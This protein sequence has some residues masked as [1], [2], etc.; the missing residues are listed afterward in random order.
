MAIWIMMAMWIFM[1]VVM[2]K[3]GL[4]YQNI[5][6]TGH[7]LRL[8][9]EGVKSNRDALGECF[10]RHRNLSGLS[11]AISRGAQRWQFG[12]G[13]DTG[14]YF[15]LADAS[16][17]KR[18]EIHKFSGNVQ[19]LRDIAGD[20]FLQLLEDMSFADEVDLSLTW[21]EPWQNP[22]VAAGFYHARINL[23][24]F[25]YRAADAKVYLEVQ[26]EQKHV[27][28]QYL[29][30]KLNSHE[31]R[32]VTFKA[33]EVEAGQSYQ[34]R[35]WLMAK[36]D[37]YALNDR[38]TRTIQGGLWTGLLRCGW[39]MR[40]GPMLSPLLNTDSL[41]DLYLSTQTIPTNSSSP[42]LVLLTPS[43]PPNKSLNHRGLAPKPCLLISIKMV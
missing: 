37:S 25:G 41:T 14:L 11:K 39:G 7:W 19:I 12:A 40:R 15:G 26:G 6:Q 43:S 5:S 33:F 4:L 27:L 21:A 24:N 42:K 29:D 8:K 36:G 18:L 17:I 32:E 20:Q 35:V 22:K 38:L 3:R 10:S 31:M 30:I 2:V 28:K 9:L 23:Q 13:N 1:S 16:I 34:L